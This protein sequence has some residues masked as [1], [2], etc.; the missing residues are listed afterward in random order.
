MIANKPHGLSEHFPLSRSWERVPEGRERE[1]KATC[2]KTYHLTAALVA[3]VLGLCASMTQAAGLDGLHFP[4]AEIVQQHEQPEALRIYPQGTLRRVSN[5][6]R[7]E[8]QIRAEGRLQ[9]RT[10]QL[11]NGQQD[12]ADAVASARQTLHQA[13][14]E[15]LYWCI[16]RECGSSALWANTVFGNA[17]LYGPDDQQSYLLYRLPEPQANSLLAL[18]AITRGNRRSYLHIEQ[19][20]ASEPLGE[21]LPAAAT[22]LRQLRET[23]EL[24]LPALAEPTEAWAERL[25]QCLNLA[26]TMRVKLEGA[27]AL[28][29]QQALL[30][31]RVRATRLEA[32][33]N[34]E[35]PL[36]LLLVR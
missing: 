3:L 8:A 35:A 4:H 34:N 22:L 32:V 2:Q 6:V 31:Q 11:P 26:S 30:A 24:L 17:Q 36:R 1:V 25:A 16:G 21:L 33:E 15:L 18:Y 13:G 28:A 29:W 14:A 5:Q 23:G 9:I 7:Y 20:D 10:L 27:G 19:L 12:L